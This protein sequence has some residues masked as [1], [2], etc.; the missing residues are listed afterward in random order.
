MRN[1]F[2]IYVLALLTAVVLPSCSM[3]S[4]TYSPAAVTEPTATLASVASTPT[5]TP[6]T[7]SAPNLSDIA[8]PG[9]SSEAPTLGIT[10]TDQTDISPVAGAINPPS[11]VKAGTRITYYVA[12]ASVANS[13]WS[14]VE[15][16]NGEWQ[17]PNT[18]KRYHRTDDPG[19][20]EG[21]PTAASEGLYQVD[22]MGVEGSNVVLAN[23]LL[24]L[25]RDRGM[26]TPGLTSGGRYSTSS[27][28]DLWIHPTILAQLEKTGVPGMLVLHGPYDVFGTTYDAIGI[29]DNSPGSYHSY[30]YN[31][32]TG[33]LLAATSR[34]EGKKS[35]LKPEGGDPPQANTLITITRFVGVRQRNAP[36]L[37]TQNPTWLA[38]FPQLSYSGKYVWT[39]PYDP[40]TTFTYPM[41]FSVKFGKGGTTWLPFTSV[42]TIHIPTLQPT[43]GSGVATGAG[44]FWV[45]KTVL[46]RLKAGQ[47][48]DEDP[49]TSEVVT[50]E[51]VGTSGGKKTVLVSSEMPGIS[52]KFTY[53]A[54]TG[55]LITYTA[56]VE[57][58]GSTAQ[59]AIDKAP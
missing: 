54:N 58:M 2:I 10:A 41:E 59:M 50:I 52:T 8:L 15:D 19:Y 18:G 48:I 32:S 9:L 45:D 4:P 34:T 42:T 40:T 55:A 28:M 13:S 20:D 37:N 14:W 38:R 5:A 7:I 26:F 23:T 39:N 51:T 33:V 49:I 24:L 53:D 31:S 21:V 22:V 43:K 6:P 56:T 57:L 11:W 3:E 36:G 30:V 25:H 12:S 1:R 27:V 47:K 46:Q 16:E 35:P 44:I 29:L 17:D